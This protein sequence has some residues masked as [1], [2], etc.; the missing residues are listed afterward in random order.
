VEALR[1]SELA[2]LAGLPVSTLRYYERIGLVPPPSRLPNGYR[3]YDETV[4]ELLAF[5]GRAK[6]MGVPLEEISELIEL[7][8]NGGCQPLQ[9]RIKAFLI[10][11]I[12]EVRLQ[13]AE[14]SRFEAQLNS[15]LERLDSSDRSIEQCDLD[16]ACVHL[17]PSD[18]SLQECSRSPVVTR[19]AACSLEHNLR[20]ERIEEWRRLISRGQTE[21]TT[22]GAWI[23]FLPSPDVVTDIASLCAQ[24]SLCC[25]FFCFSIDISTE[26]VSL[27]VEVPDLPEAMAICDAVF[28]LIPEKT[29]A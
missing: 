5:I 24:E 28:G 19:E 22:N 10:D 26:A 17:D 29:V 7:W 1:I 8:S 3:V 27:R 9:N 25:T 6:R 14:M 13:R 21:R 18:V 23:R 15:L 4:A 20:L 11:K 2:E 16:C 12:G